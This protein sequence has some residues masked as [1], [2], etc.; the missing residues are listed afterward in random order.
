MNPAIFS[1]IQEE[2]KYHQL[3]QKMFDE[4]AK[5]MEKYRRREMKRSQK[6]ENKKS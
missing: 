6:N 1:I 3:V 5:K 4:T 2:N